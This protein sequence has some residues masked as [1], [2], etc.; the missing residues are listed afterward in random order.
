MNTK[1][2][3]SLNQKVVDRI[4]QLRNELRL[5]QEIMA[6]R[7]NM[8][9]S[10]YIRLEKGEHP[11]TLDETMQIASVLNTNFNELTNSGNIF[12]NH[13]NKSVFNHGNIIIYNV[14]KDDMDDLMN[15]EK[16]E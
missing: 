8:S 14:S 16:G 15:M 11:L 2:K 9:K 3:E 12:N 6:Q 7:M 10:S 4:I 13:G 1:I 5:S